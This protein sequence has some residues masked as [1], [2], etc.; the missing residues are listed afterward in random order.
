MKWVAMNKVV[1]PMTM[2]D[3]G[4]DDGSGGY[5]DGRVGD[6]DDGDC[7]E[8]MLWNIAQEVL[9]RSTK[10]L[11]NL[12]IVKSAERERERESLYGVEKVVQL[13]GQHYVLCLRY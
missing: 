5:D 11:E 3:D 9:L 4:D 2:D 8:E 12:K 1:V 7:L 6:E 10:G 13:I